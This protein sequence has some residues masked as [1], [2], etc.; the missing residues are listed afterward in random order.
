MAIVV[1]GLN[2]ILFKLDRLSNPTAMAAALKTAVKAGA[3]T[4]NTP[5]STD[6][7]T[8]KSTA[9]PEG[10]L[11]DGLTVVQDNVGPRGNP[12]AIVLYEDE[13]IGR[14]GA[15]VD[16]G[17]REVHGG[18]LKLTKKG[19][20]AANSK[21]AVTGYVEGTGYF[22]EAV[23]AVSEEVTEIVRSRLKAEVDKLLAN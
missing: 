20:I 3:D 14:V 8:T 19:K 7:W 10:A 22:Q 2:A 23:E 13:H 9:L 1:N 6:K 16:R 17:H 5:V 18:E 12:R 21:G 4:E 11:R 15:W